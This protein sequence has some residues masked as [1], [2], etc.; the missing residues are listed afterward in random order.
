[1]GVS[2][3]VTSALMPGTDVNLSGVGGNTQVTIDATGA[4]EIVYGQVRKGVKTITK[5]QVTGSSITT[6]SRAALSGGINLP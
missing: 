1:M 3:A 2:T 5:Q 4:S 6:S